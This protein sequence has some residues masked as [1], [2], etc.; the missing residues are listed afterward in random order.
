MGDSG[1]VSQ[2]LDHLRQGN[3]SAAE[4]LWRHY[5]DRMS[6]R[7]RQHLVGERAVSDE[8]DAAI[9]AF[10]TFC[11][12]VADGQFEKIANRNE[13]W[14]LLVVLTR[15]K[16]TQ[17][18]R[19]EKRQKRG[20]GIRHQRIGVTSDRSS[21]TIGWSEVE[22]RG[23]TSTF[24]DGLDLQCQELLETL[25]DESLQRV[26]VLRLEGYS[27]REIAGQLKVALRSVER[28]LHRIRAI[29]ERECAL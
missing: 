15:R 18:R 17:H 9:S 8:E 13:L 24:Q 21:D 12:H 10:D 28:K 11:R 7:A 19:H 16:V 29:W 23:A 25:D 5:F 20:G 26:A 1:S 14:G 2:L 27:N 4:G 6:A 22:R 3:H